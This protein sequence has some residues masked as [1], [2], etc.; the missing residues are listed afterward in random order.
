MGD[1]V[2]VGLVF[3]EGADHPVTPLPDGAVAIDLIAV[4]VR[5]TRDIEPLGGHALS[6]ARPSEQPVDLF[7]IRL[8]GLVSQESIDLGKAGW[9]AGEVKADPAQPELSGS[10]GCWA[11]LIIFKLASNEV[12]HR[13]VC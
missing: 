6:V 4:A 11:E 8:R 12:I 9:Q 10:C 3:L 2:I 7:L 5:V 1:K 13:S